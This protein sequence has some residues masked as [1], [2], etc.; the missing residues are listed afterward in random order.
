MPV[1]QFSDDEFYDILSAMIKSIRGSDPDAAKEI[2]CFK[3]PFS[4]I[5]ETFCILFMCLQALINSLSNASS[6]TET[7]RIIPFIFLQKKWKI[8]CLLIN[9]QMTNFMIFY[10][11]PFGFCLIFSG[12][13]GSWSL[14]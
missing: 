5:S 11:Y 9:F 10:L 3:A 12:T 1:N 8:L 6:L 4:T 13:T 7:D 2:I 14:R